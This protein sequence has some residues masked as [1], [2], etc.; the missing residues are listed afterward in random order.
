[1]Q[2]RLAMVVNSLK[3][4]FVAV[5]HHLILLFVLWVAFSVAAIFI[6][7]KRLFSYSNLVASMN[8]CLEILFGSFQW[9][10]MGKENWL[11]AVVWFWTYVLLCGMV[12]V[13]MFVALVM[14]A[15]GAVKGRALMADPIWTQARKWHRQQHHASDWIKVDEMEELVR[16][17]IEVRGHTRVTSED[18]RHMV[19]GLP[20]E[21]AGGLIADARRQ[22]SETESSGLSL[23][24]MCQLIGILGNSVKDL[25]LRLESESERTLEERKSALAADAL[26]WL[27]RMSL[28]SSQRSIEKRNSLPA[29]P[30]LIAKVGAV[31]ARM[32]R[33]CAYV[34]DSLAWTADFSSRFSVQLDGIEAR[35]KD[36]CVIRLPPVDRWDSLSMQDVDG[37]SNVERI[38]RRL[39]SLVEEKGV[40]VLAYATDSE[41][42]GPRVLQLKT[43]SRRSESEAARSVKFAT[44]TSV[45]QDR[46]AK[47]LS[48]RS[49]LSGGSSS[50]KRTL[51]R[52]PRS[53]SRMSQSSHRSQWATSTTWAGAAVRQRHPLTS[54][55]DTDTDAR[56]PA[57]KGAFVGFSV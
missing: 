18:L 5:S 53:L 40:S 11:T 41:L 19:P 46:D 22:K 29:D 12:L 32:A 26:I 37:L 44:S 20:E 15:Y 2:P 39:A 17:Q 50:G 30:E 51:S 55:T 38:K 54:D 21:Q 8:S 36:R 43:I 9:S 33:I 14:D 57:M 27:E 48:P 34:E 49:L 13:N 28:E 23:S 56:Q 1:M 10:E 3:D 6:F 25:D 31:S 47:S 35:I 24:E 16:L 7:G 52:E 42:G 45:V 4:S